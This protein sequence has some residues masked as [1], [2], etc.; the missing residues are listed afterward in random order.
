MIVY[1]ASDDRPSV[2]GFY[3]AV[4]KNSSGKVKVKQRRRG[5]G[6]GDRTVTLIGTTADG[7]CHLDRGS[8]R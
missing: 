3:V 5:G 8:L 1:I 6:G 4:T 7:I 2:G